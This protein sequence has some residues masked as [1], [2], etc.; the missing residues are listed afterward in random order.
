VTAVANGGTQYSVTRGI[1]GTTAATH[2]ASAPVYHLAS[3]TVIAPFPANF[4]GS[5]YC[6]NW[7]YPVAL[8]D[9][10]VACAEL[11]VTNDVGNSTTAGINLTHNDD[12]GL[13]TLSGGQYSIQVDGYLAVEQSV[14]PPIVLE[15]SHAVRDVYAV[16]GTAADAVVQVQ[17]NVNGVLYCAPT[18]QPG[19]TLSSSV[20]GNTLPPLIMGGQV[21][22]AVKSVGQTN[23]G[24]NLTVLIRL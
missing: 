12:K 15:A 9:V 10:R 18:F 7:S 23:P 20:N 19:A 6:G 14:A 22:A 21:T 4:F 13:R 11:F 3:Q 2:A 8:P 1:D 24:A 5:P 16:L 17:V